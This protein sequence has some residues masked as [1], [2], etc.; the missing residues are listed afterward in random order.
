MPT[1]ASHGQNYTCDIPNASGCW[2]VT[3]EFS[4]HST[5]ADTQAHIAV[6][7]CTWLCIFG[8]KKGLMMFPEWQCLLLL[9]VN[10]SDPTC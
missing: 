1:A 7:G 10:E 6:C 9:V 5:E 8:E 3:A 2:V 4:Q